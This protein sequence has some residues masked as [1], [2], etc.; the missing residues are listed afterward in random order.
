[1]YHYCTHTQV[2]PGQYTD[3]QKGGVHKGVYLWGEL[4]ALVSLYGEISGYKTSGVG[5]S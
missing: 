1:M 3:F 5:R 2:S 4:G